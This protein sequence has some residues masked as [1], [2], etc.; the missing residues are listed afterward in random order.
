MP[1]CPHVK[2]EFL[3]RAGA[4]RRILFIFGF[5]WALPSMVAVFLPLFQ[6]GRLQKDP[7]YRGDLLLV[8]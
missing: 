5:W 1:G 7:S 3:T 6:R 8:F 2:R 4:P